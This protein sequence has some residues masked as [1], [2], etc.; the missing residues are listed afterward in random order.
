MGQ[1]EIFCESFIVGCSGWKE[2]I[3]FC[4]CGHVYLCAEW[5][6]RATKRRGI[7]EE[8]K[9]LRGFDILMNSVY[10]PGCFVENVLRC[11]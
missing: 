4:V 7:K 3:H 1:K 11:G 9:K 8:E 5:V 2:G 6:G 10:L